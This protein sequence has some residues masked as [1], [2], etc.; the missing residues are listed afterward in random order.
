MKIEIDIVNLTPHAIE[1]LKP[2]GKLVKFP[3]KGQARLRQQDYRE[4]RLGDF[5]FINYQSEP[6]VEGLPK[7]ESSRL[8]IVSSIVQLALKGMRSDLIS[9][10]I[11]E[12]DSKGN[13]ICCRAFKL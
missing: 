12:K 4:L 5:R 11:V 8:F 3:S 1:Y 7:E 9:P 6:N 13:V 10:T 2:D